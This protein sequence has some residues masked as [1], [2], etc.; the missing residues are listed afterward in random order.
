MSY[1]TNISCPAQ[2]FRWIGH[3]AGVMETEGLGERWISILLDKGLIKDPADIYYLT[4]DQLVALE[5]MG[6]VLADKILK[7]IEASKSRN[8]S[9][10]L[11]ALGIRHVGGE[12]AQ[13][14][15]AHFHNLDALVDASAEDIR[16]V[17]GIGPKIADSIHAYFQDEQK[18]AII[19][20]LRKASVNFEYKRPKR[21]E[22]PLTGQS[23]V[24]TGTLASVP[25]GKAESLVSS[26]GAEAGSS[27]TRKI[28]YLV[29]GADPGSKLQ[30]AQNY[31]ITVLDEDGFLSLLREHGVDA[32]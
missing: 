29:A 15:S 24:F 22:G 17:E 13:L 7:N 3:F 20:K 11:F 16:N 27:V 30:K 32:A 23:F 14:L 4:K 2:M 9:L 25:R 12:V 21:V 26:L 31:G 28:T 6:S 5:R 8:L 19:E 18:R 1:C 10:L